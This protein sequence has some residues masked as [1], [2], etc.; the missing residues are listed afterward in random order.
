MCFVWQLLFMVFFPRRMS[1]LL[2]LTGAAGRESLQPSFQT[3]SLLWK[4]IS[5]TSVHT[6]FITD[7]LQITQVHFPKQ[8]VESCFVS[9]H[10]LKPVALN[11]SEC[12]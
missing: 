6:G 7:H 12:V 10:H 3:F 2:I 5:Y 11:D 1:V 4:H 9:D 8:T